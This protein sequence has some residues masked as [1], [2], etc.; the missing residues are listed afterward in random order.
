ML[1]SLLVDFVASGGFG[2]E[3]EA[4]GIV[5]WKSLASDYTLSIRADL[6]HLPGLIS[7]IEPRFK[8]QM[9]YASLGP[10]DEVSL[11]RR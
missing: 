10:S 2:K 5:I 8:S 3:D 1:A 6:G 4:G 7:A 9:A 11:V